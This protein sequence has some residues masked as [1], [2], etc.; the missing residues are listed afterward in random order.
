[1]RI[2]LGARRWHLVRQS[3]TESLLLA[4]AG[5]LVGVPLAMWATHAL[6]RL[7]TFGVPLLQNASLDPLALAVTIGLTTLSGVACGLLPALHLTGSHCGP[8]AQNATHQRTTSRSSVLTRNALVVAEVALACVLLVGAG[9]LIR[10]FNALLQVN[11]GFQPQHAM[12]WRVDPVRGFDS[13]AEV[14]HYF[15]AAVRRIA[16]LPGVEAVGLSDTLPLGRNRTWGAGAVGAQYPE[17]QYPIAYPRIVDSHYLQTMRIP[18]IA[19][20][21][22]DEDYNPKGEKAVVI[23]EN[24]A[25]RLWPDRNP[26]G[27]KIHVNGESTVIGVVGNVRHSSLEELGGNEMYLDYRQ[28]ADWNAMEMVVRSNR[29]PESLVPEVRAALAAFDPSLPN[30]EFYELD[31]LVD[32]AVA[33]RRFI[34][35]LLGFFS[36]LALT[37]AAL[38][39]YGV[40]AYSVIQRTQEI[41]IRLAIG[42][43]RRDVLQLILRAGL[44]LVAIGVAVGL[45]SAFALTRLLQSLL[46]GVTACDP[47]VFAGDAALLLLVAAVACL[48]PALRA[49]RVDPVI[50]LRAE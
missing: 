48:V 37:L 1:V 11:L 33:P 50:A 13:G 9:L 32:D 8:T 5:S 43:Q 36:M 41:G 6:A 14:D 24:L 27:Q 16:A 42:A 2:A 22:F 47:L 4:F 30:G 46:F 39:L 25:R 18:L 20:R 3:L 35:Q 44:K 29:P 45:A 40:I 17:G 19:G 7:P 34:T 38:G 21:F 12:A 23:N 49:T 26:L 28:G 31:R 15:G 10:S